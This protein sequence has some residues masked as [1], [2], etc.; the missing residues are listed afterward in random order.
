MLTLRANNIDPEKD[1]KIVD[2]GS[3]DAVV[4]AVYSGDVDVGSVYVDAR[5]RLED[6]YPDVM[7]TIIMSESHGNFNMC[8]IL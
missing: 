8:V 6:E 2:A 5:T 1:L 3:H 4:A 7:D